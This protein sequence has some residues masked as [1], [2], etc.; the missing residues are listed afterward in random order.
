MS[1]TNYIRLPLTL[2]EELISWLDE[3]ALKAKASGGH[4]LTRTSA[5]RACFT[6]IMELNV[7]VG[8]VKNEEELKS[9]IMEAYLKS[10]Q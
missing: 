6:A 8:G 5:I 9:R 7:D 4:K 3:I 10:A 1:E 2:S